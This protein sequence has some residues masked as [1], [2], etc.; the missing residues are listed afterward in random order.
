MNF[1]RDN[2]FKLNQIKI[3]KLLKL[4]GLVRDKDC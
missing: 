1:L 4:V 2:Q 3:Y